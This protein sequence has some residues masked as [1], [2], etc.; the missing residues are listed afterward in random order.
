[1]DLEH[2]GPMMEASAQITGLTYQPKVFSGTQFRVGL[3]GD[4]MR[5]MRV[6]SDDVVLFYFSGHGSRQ[7]TKKSVWPDLWYRLDKA[8]IDLESVASEITAMR[9]RLGL[10][11]ADCCNNVLTLSPRIKAAA[12]HAE[13]DQRVVTNLGRLFLQS[14]GVWLAA[15]AS[16]GDYSYADD[17]GGYYTNALLHSFNYGL[18]YSEQLSWKD[19]F[20]VAAWTLQGVQEPLYQLWSPTKGV[21]AEAA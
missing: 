1:V 7:K 21:E 11:I 4:Y 3:V 14:R 18:I 17:N 9:P 5:Q 20:E 15:A 8:D 13:L 6:E 2:L 12:P 19:V 16:P 10:V